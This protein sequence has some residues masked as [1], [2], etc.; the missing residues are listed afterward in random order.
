MPKEQRDLVCDRCNK[1]FN[2]YGSWYSHQKQKHDDPN[3]SCKHCNEK[4]KT[5]ALRNTHYYRT[6][7]ITK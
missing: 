3:I 4:F 2:V 7:E 6:H 5:I 1:R